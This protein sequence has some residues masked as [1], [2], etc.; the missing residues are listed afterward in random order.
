MSKR[1]GRQQKRKAKAEIKN[2]NT[3][4]MINNQTVQTASCIIGMVKD[5]SPNSICF[6]PNRIQEGYRRHVIHEFNIG[7]IDLSI[8]N[9]PVQAEV[10]KSVDLY[11]LEV[12]LSESDFDRA[13]HFRVGF[14]DA[15]AG[16]K[17][18]K[19]GFKH[20]TIERISMEIARH[21]KKAIK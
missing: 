17:I 19:E 16:Y 15:C 1:Y 8:A 20:T 5:I 7:A 11:D 3:R 18:S 2:L 10:I 4:L 21:L 13:I 6:E 12:A 9:E 14:D